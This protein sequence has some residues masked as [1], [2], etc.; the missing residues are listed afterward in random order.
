MLAVVNIVLV[1]SNLSGDGAGD[2]GIII[3]PQT[4]DQAPDKLET[5]SD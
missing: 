5:D 2:G 1:K 3:I 4:R